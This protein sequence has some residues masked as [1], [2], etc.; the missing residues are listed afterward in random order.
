MDKYVYMYRLQAMSYHMCGLVNVR[1]LLMKEV[2]CSYGVERQ[3]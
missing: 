1:A 2:H 3:L